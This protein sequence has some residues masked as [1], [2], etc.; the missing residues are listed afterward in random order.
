MALATLEMIANIT[1]Y[2]FNPSG[3]QRTMVQAIAEINNGEQQAYDAT[4]PFVQALSAS[5]YETAAFMQQHAAESRKRYPSLAQTQ[6]DLYLHM[7]DADYINRFSIPA[8]A[9]FSLRFNKNELINAMKLEPETGYMK[10][11]IPRNTYFTADVYTFSLQYPVDI[12]LLHNNSFQITYDNDVLSPLQELTDNQISYDIVVD[13]QFEE[14]VKFDLPTL[15]FSISQR[16]TPISY[17]KDLVMSME[18]AD[19]FYHARVY[20][21][22][23]KTKKWDELAT[24]HAETV[25]D[26]QKPTAVLRV[27]NGF[28][29]VK[30]PQI[31]VSTD[32]LSSSIRVDLYQTKG[33]INV[34]LADY[35]GDAVSITW[36][37][38]DSNEA[39]N[40]FSAAL[41]GMNVAVYSEETVID[42]KNE[43]PFEE[44][45]SNVVN[46]ATGPIQ[47]AITPAMLE[48]MIRNAGYGVVKNVDNVTNRVYL[49]TRE[50]PSPDIIKATNAASNG[51]KLLTSAAASIETLTTSMEALAR[52]TTVYNNGESLTV[53]PKTLYQIVDG[54]TKPVNE[55][56]VARILAL[57]P[58]KRA[59]EVTNGNYLYTPF[60]YVLDTSNSAFEIRPYYLDD[61]VAES[62]VFVK[63]NDTTLML[64]GTANYALVRAANGYLLRVY[65]RSDD[66]YKAIPDNQVFVQL[67]YIPFGERDRAYLNG[68]LVG[69]TNAGERVFDFAL[70][71]SFNVDANDNLDLTTFTMYNAESRITKTPLFNAFDL[72]YSTS[73]VLSGRWVTNEVDNV[74]GRHLL[75]N[76]VAGINHER[77]KLKFGEALE[78]L[79]TR[80]RSVVSSIVYD[81]W[82]EDAQAFYKQDIYQYNG[83]GTKLSIVDG[84]LQYTVLHKK[85]DPVLDADGNITYE[86]RKGDLKRDLKGELIP[87]NPRGMLRQIDLMLL[88]GVYWFATD[89]L[90]A[91]YRT[92]LTNA[93]VKWIAN[94]LESFKDS[95]LDKTRIYFYPKT[96][97]GSIPVYVLD[98]AKTSIPAGQAFTVTLGVSKQVY[99]NDTL[100][101]RLKE[102]TV[103]VLSD[104]L[105]QATVSMSTVTE[106]LKKAYG[107]DVIDIQIS[108]LG[109]S[110][111]YSVV[112]VAEE[113]DRLS[114]RKRLVALADGTLAAEEDVTVQFRK[115]IKS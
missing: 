89:T 84:K 85:G 31:Y 45:R 68:T 76:Q 14:Y 42:G 90:T 106:A 32:Q 52:L 12:R 96:T 36:K 41:P 61:P 27:L 17:A 67:A 109:G 58:D 24:T 99:D 66:A 74:L 81:A 35:R 62:K 94:D 5:A 83:D 4:I 37:S 40:P 48:T 9:K 105:K 87:V 108:N 101:E 19:Q 50:M 110:A 82:E 25:Y 93:L 43:M 6:E 113:T 21:K 13:S 92:S 77:L 23:P 91:T 49:A 8:K 10:L 97:S 51:K 20:H 26:I 88:E 72:V 107:S 69:K 64:V 63:Q 75:P 11:T 1:A 39:T 29:L 73:A 47:K 55:T 102:S 22:N 78:M 98:E 104:S 18:I 3:I 38:W 112:T 59:Q 111:N 80:A 60:H 57:P 114:I 33:A 65:T 34:P 86:H 15:Q 103:S 46:N 44:L 54:I 16:T 7:S 79:W 100:R 71:T 28:L 115:A 70:D 53:T 2:R 95:L 30:I 56:E